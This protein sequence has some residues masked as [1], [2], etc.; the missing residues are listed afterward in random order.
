MGG[1]SSPETSE[2]NSTGPHGWRAAFSPTRVRQALGAL[3]PGI[4]GARRRII[5]SQ[6]APPRAFREG[7]G[8]PPPRARALAE[9]EQAELSSE[10]GR[11]GVARA[12]GL[13]VPRTGNN[14]R[15]CRVRAP[16]RAKSV[17]VFR[18]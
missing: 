16:A 4:S 13:G 17:A 15:V 8:R 18:D 10:E 3:A 6:G 2:P 1:G 7:A 14:T 11:G 12:L 5:T 9:P